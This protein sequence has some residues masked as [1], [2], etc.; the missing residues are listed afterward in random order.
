MT[1][2]K[3]PWTL[4]SLACALTL[5]TGACG[6]SH[7]IPIGGDDAGMGPVCGD[8]TCGAGEVCCAPCHVCAASSAYCAC[9][10]DGG[11]TDAG[12]HDAGGHDAGGHDAGG[13]DAGGHDA[14]SLDAGG[15][16]AG[17]GRVPLLHRPAPV[18]CSHTRGPGDA[19]PTLTFAA[20]TADSDCTADTNGRCLVSMGG[21]YTNYCSYDGCFVDTDCSGAT[22]VCRCRETSNDANVCVGGNCVVD[23]DCGPGGYCSPSR[24]FDRINYGVA[25]Y[26]CHTP[27]DTCI[28]DADCE[29]DGGTAKCAY[30]TTDMRWE[31][32]SMGFYPP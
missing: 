7:D 8:T 32:S 9:A 16:D 26:Y 2:M 10:D 20:C 18:D 4:L 15:H 29:T 24:Q 5:A 23:A 12:G 3:P 30:S 31:C 11:T 25:G 28:D 22:P 14:G 21:A 27:G 1:S 17:T 6:S 19:D 13:L